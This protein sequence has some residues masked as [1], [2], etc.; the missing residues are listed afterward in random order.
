MA[1]SRN[2]HMRAMTDVIVTSGVVSVMLVFHWFVLFR[3]DEN[4]TGNTD[5]PIMFGVGARHPS[6]AN[7]FSTVFKIGQKRPNLR[8]KMGFQTYELRI[9]QQVFRVRHV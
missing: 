3:F 5:S 6:N 7:L 2:D 9:T 1:P 8:A 4:R